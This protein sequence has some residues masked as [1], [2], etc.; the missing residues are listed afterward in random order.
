MLKKLQRQLEAGLG[1]DKDKDIFVLI[2]DRVNTGSRGG[3]DDD[4]ALP[5]GSK[6]R[7]RLSSKAAP[8]TPL[9]SK[10]TPFVPK[11]AEKQTQAKKKKDEHAGKGE[12]AK[13]RGEKSEKAAPVDVSTKETE[14][15][16]AEA[17]KAEA[18]LPPVKHTFIHYA[19]STT[20]S[21]GLSRCSSAPAL[22]SLSSS[23]S[24]DGDDDEESEVSEDDD[25]FEDDDDDEVPQPDYRPSYEKAMAHERGECRPCAFFLYKDDGCRWGDSCSFCHLC[26]KGEIKA[27]RKMRYASRRAYRGKQAQRSSNKNGKQ[28]RTRV[29]LLKHLGE[30]L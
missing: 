12:A 20:T 8:F 13:K 9:S 1:E 27:R 26:P 11:A 25:D 19:E 23:S 24:A 15:L 18:T 21:G 10:A 29:L 14:D 2:V 5:G 3:R 6:L 4:D 28:P 17:D 7:T 22:L 30:L 16:S